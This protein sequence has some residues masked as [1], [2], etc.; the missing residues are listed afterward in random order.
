MNDLRFLLSACEFVVLPAIYSI[1]SSGPLAQVFAHEKAVIVSDLGVYSE[2]I[3]PGEYG[4]LAKVADV[5][6]LEKNMIRLLEEPGLK[7]RIVKNVAMI[8]I[9]RKWG[10]IAGKTLSVYKDLK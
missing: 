7:D 5:G 10:T 4:L 8:H 3:K 1:A 2:E 6:D 9:E